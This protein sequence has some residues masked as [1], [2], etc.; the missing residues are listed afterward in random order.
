MMNAG[1]PAFGASYTYGN[2]P[3]S[4]NYLLT[5]TPKITFQS[6][7]YRWNFYTLSNDSFLLEWDS[8]RI[9]G[10]GTIQ[11]KVSGSDIVNKILVGQKRFNGI[12]DL[13]F[14]L[15][16]DNNKPIYN[17]A[18]SDMCANFPNTFKNLTDTSACD[19]ISP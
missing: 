17:L 3:D 16:D 5:F 7:S 11:V 6:G 14:V 19:Q 4:S 8:S 10:L 15:A 9:T 2:D 12:S 18:I 13:H 1:K